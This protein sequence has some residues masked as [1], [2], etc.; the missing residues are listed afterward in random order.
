[1]LT[2]AVTACS[3]T[4]AQTEIQT[5]ALLSTA[6][7]FSGTLWQ[8]SVNLFTSLNGGFAPVFV[9]TGVVCA[10]AFFFGLRLGRRVLGKS[11]LLPAVAA[12]DYTNLRVRF[13][14]VWH[15]A[16][17]CFC[18]LPPWLCP[19]PPLVSGLVFSG[20]VFSCL[21]MVDDCFPRSLTPGCRRRS[22]ALRASSWAPT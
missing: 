14:D 4:H 3:A 18:L 8:P 1:V 22:V 21:L 5:A 13:F 19:S 9:G 10:S 15:C 16:C 6:T 2:L 12:P 11:G 17:S 7:M 20:L